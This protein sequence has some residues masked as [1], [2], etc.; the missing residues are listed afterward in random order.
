VKTLTH[1]NVKELAAHLTIDAQ[2][3]LIY[4]MICELLKMKQCESERFLG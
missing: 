2:L 4:Q 3:L 1:D